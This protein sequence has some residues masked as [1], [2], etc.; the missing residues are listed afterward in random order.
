MATVSSED[1]SARM[2][3]TSFMTGAGLKK[4]RPA[5]LSGRPVTAASSETERAEVL[6]ARMADF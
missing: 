1:C 2:T 3:S 6:V 5:T 4:W